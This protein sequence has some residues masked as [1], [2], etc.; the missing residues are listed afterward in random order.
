MKT[1]Y[2]PLLLMAMVLPSSTTTVS[3]ESPERQ[4]HQSLV[5]MT[6]QAADQPAAQDD[7]RRQNVYIVEVEGLVD[8]GMHSYIQ[9]SLNTAERDNAAGVILHMDTFGGLVDAA[10]K[11]RKTLLDSP[12]P[13]VTYI[14]R[15]AASAGALIALST[16]TI[17]MASG[18]SMGAATVVEGTG[19]RADEKMQSYMRGLMRSTAESKG[20][21][22][23]L[24]EAM[25]DERIA[26]EGVIGEG[27]LLTL[28]TSEA[29]ELGMADGNLNSLAEV[30]EQMG[31]QGYEQIHMDQTWQESV[32]R[33]LS[34]PAV[35]IVLILML[36]GGIYLEVQSPGLGVPG[37]V[38]SLAA[39]L[40]FAPH[41][42]LGFATWEI[43]VFFLGVLLILV[44]IFLVPGFGVPGITGVTLMLLSLLASMVGNVGLSFPGIEHMAGPI[45]IL[46]ITLLLG[47]A[48]AVSLARYIPQN[49]AL[50]TLILS[51]TT[52]S[53]GEKDMHQVEQP[54]P[55]YE[56][57][58]G[59]A[60]TSLRPAGTV[61]IDE[62]R[63]DVV[64][65]GDYIEK[66]A[67]V[68][69]VSHIGNRV[70]VRKIS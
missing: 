48:L 50:S 67:K 65:E 52:E 47:I 4:T 61:L 68:Q 57:S 34:N 37:F 29:V 69:V 3:A 26:I 59:V 19:E 53:A 44:E 5:Q 10:D 40:F 38:A 45:W 18:S 8:N 28:S 56:G 63:V 12:V 62:H 25:V 20:R 23:R 32:L 21:D 43:L 30:M 36:L 66:G 39:V 24:A 1:V 35:I 2:L 27:E 17:F 15:N 13:T 51:T 49:R 60:L 42:I 14:D 31:W 6:G 22:P 9:R 64:S 11:I 58:E 46:A 41:Y 55:G 54:K 7:D 33:F 70:T 16:D